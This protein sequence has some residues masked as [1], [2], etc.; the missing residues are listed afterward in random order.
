MV[1]NTNQVFQILRG[2][3]SAAVTNLQS[4]GPLPLTN[5]MHLCIGLPVRNQPAL[6]DL[7]QRLYDPN[8][9]RYHQ[10]LTCQQF[11]EQFGPS[12]ADYQSLIAFAKAHGLAVTATS[13]NR[14]LLNVEASVAD[15]EKTFHVTLRVYRHPKEN[16]TFFAPDTEPSVY[17]SVPILD[18]SGLDDFIVP[19]P[20]DL[21][22]Q[23]L[24]KG[25]QPLGT[26]SFYGSYTSGDLRAA[27]APG[28]P[29]NGTGQIVGILTFDGYY[30][31]DIAEYAAMCSI[32]MVALTNVLLDGFN[33]APGGNNLETALDIEMSMGMATNLS[34]IIVYEGAGFNGDSILNQMAVDNL[35]KQLS[36]SWSYPTS[37]NTPQELQELAAQGQVIFQA[38]GDSGNW[39]YNLTPTP[40]DEPGLVDVGGTVLSTTGSG[41]SW[42]S[43]SAWHYSGGGITDFLIPSWQTN[44]DMTLNQGSTTRRNMPDVAMPSESVFMVGNNGGLYGIG[45]TSASAPMWAGFTALINQQADQN[46]NPP[47]GFLNPAIYAIG[48]STNYH[49]CF[50]DIISGDNTNPNNPTN[51]YAVTGYDLCTGWGTPTGSNLINALAPFNALR[52]TPVTIPVLAGQIGGPFGIQSFSLTNAGTGTLGWT[53]VNTCAWLN[54]D[55]TGGTLAPGQTASL[56][57]TVGSLANFLPAGQYTTSLLFGT[58]DGAVQPR[59]FTLTVNPLVQNGGFEIGNFD[60]WTLAGTNVPSVVASGGSQPPDVYAGSWGARLSNSGSLGYLSQ[61]VPT[62]AGKTYLLS[63]WLNSSVNPN[64]PKKTTPNQF[65]VSWNGTTIFNQSNIGAIGWTNLQFIVSAT[66]SSTPLQFGFRDDPWALGLDEITLQPIVSPAILGVTKTNRAVL[67]SWEAAAGVH[68]QLQYTTNMTSLYWLNLGSP[69]LATNLIFSTTDT[70]ASDA[71]RFYRVLFTP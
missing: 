2:H 57:A 71:Q 17:T 63:C 64:P 32:P 3:V 62:V 34:G 25:V 13:P 18:V 56:A 35:A 24:D 45:G 52:I 31:N 70:N 11:T 60:S 44:V 38:S 8:N 59:L 15:I 54:V 5:R 65:L 68:Y 33:G 12:E 48:E 6:T 22:A 55:S 41:G 29:L 1:P 58:S 20:M 66:G 19:K 50:H 26:G 46:A 40:I 27:Y 16:R 10:Y 7:I 67:C 4:I 37:G 21:R 9:S 28:T 23:P 43:E 51:F 69:V 49:A 47:V 53:L 39:G 14:M 30:P 36:S 42:V 61:T